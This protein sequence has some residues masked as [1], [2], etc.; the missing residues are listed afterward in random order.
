MTR[1]DLDIINEDV[2]GS[3]LQKA[4]HGNI[5]GEKWGKMIS[6]WLKHLYGRSQTFVFHFPLNSQS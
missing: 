3:I 2:K 6:E 1:K 5:R 4:S